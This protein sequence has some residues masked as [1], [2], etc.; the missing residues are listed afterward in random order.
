[1]EQCW[2]D[3]RSLKASPIFSAKTPVKTSEPV[4]PAATKASKP[5]VV[6][7]TKTSAAPDTEA[8]PETRKMTATK[9]DIV[10]GGLG[11]APKQNELVLVGCGL[12]S[13]TVDPQALRKLRDDKGESEFKQIMGVESQGSAESKVPLQA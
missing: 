1:M 3:E 10:L 9:G 5:K 7:S 12:T 8:K 6:S 13:V 4:P 11:S 2:W